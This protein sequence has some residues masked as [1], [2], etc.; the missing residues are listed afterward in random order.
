[1]AVVVIGAGVTGLTVALHCLRN[2]HR[3]VVLEKAA[4]VGGLCRSYRYDGFTFD[5]G[6]HRLFSGDPEIDGYFASILGPDHVAV[7]RVSMVKLNGRYHEWPLN[8]KSVAG[9][10]PGLML[11]CMVDLLGGRGRGDDVR[12]LRDYVISRYGETIYRTFW[13]GY[14]EKFLGLPCERVDA[15]WGSLSVARSVVDRAR[16]PRGLPDLV[17][18]VLHNSSNDLRFRYPAEG[19][20]GFADRMAAMI[21]E[22]GGEIRLGA[23][24]TALDLAGDRIRSVTAGGARIEAD[25]F[26]WTGPLPEL[27]RLA[28]R[29]EPDLRFLDLLLLNVEI[30]AEPADRWQWIYFPDKRYVFSRVSRPCAFHRGMAP[31]GTTG[32]CV[33]ITLPAGTPGAAETEELE[34]TA[35]AQ[36]VEARLLPSPAHA[37]RI[38]REIVADAYPIYRLGFRRDVDAAIEGLRPVR[39]L[40]PVG[41]GARFE[42]DNIDEAVASARAV[43]ARL[44]AAGA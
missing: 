23:P 18:S 9:M 20:G 12:T 10:S 24:V 14:T 27:C 25:Q 19:M 15:E 29:P 26:V 43:A 1:M 32:L 6:P 7:P 5:I 41:R 42:H 16:R 21:R 13:E 34:R 36:L 38:H 37:R 8:V 39:N 11:R 2:G 35:V 40:H 44:G 3:V 17:R 33:E 28:G 30:D 22:A 31:A 4:E